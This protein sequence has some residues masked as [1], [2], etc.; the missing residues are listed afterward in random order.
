[1]KYILI[2]LALPA[3][4]SD[5]CKNRKK[6][7]EGPAVTPVCIQQKIDSISKL[8]RW[9]PPAQVDEYSFNGNTVYLFSSDCCDFFNILLDTACNYVCAPSGGITGRG[10]M[11][12]P[13]FD[14]LARHVRLVW[15]DPR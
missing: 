3:M 12:C 1:M 13:G 8:P 7:T 10:D 2:L 9:N 6:A 4:L 15:K 11:K 14:S 5:T